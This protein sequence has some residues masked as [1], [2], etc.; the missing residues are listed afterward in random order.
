MLIQ[1]EI[2][3]LI[4]GSLFILSD[5]TVQRHSYHSNIKKIKKNPYKN[6]TRSKTVFFGCYVNVLKVYS[7][8]LL[9]SFKAQSIAEE[10]VTDQTIE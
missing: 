8:L 6:T 9:A 10:T 4:S 2:C 3:H 5:K 7:L 1:S